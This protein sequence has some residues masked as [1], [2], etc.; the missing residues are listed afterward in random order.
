MP[1]AY[2]R[3]INN[4]TGVCN[5]KDGDLSV[6]EFIKSIRHEPNHKIRAL[7]SLE[8]S[9]G[10]VK[11]GFKAGTIKYLMRNVAGFCSTYG[12]ASKALEIIYRLTSCDYNRYFEY[13][14]VELQEFDLLTI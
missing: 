14:V 9:I 1:G 13:F 10:D 5:L 6:T 8:K 2:L 7:K 12:I 3:L 11:N 4:H